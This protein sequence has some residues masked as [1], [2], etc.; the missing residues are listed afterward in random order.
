MEQEAALLQ[1]WSREREA[2]DELTRDMM[3]FAALRFG[4]RLEEAWKDFEMCDIPEPLDEH[5]N[6]RQIF[7]PYF[8]FHWDPFGPRSGKATQGYSGV[9][10]RAY[11]LESEDQLSDMER[12]FLEQAV[13][14]PV[15]F[16]EVLWNKPGERMDLR[17]I[18]MGGDVEVFER[19]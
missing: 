12:L 6:E 9:V 10:A 4:E 7:M 16:Y 17:D 13:T 1:L 2:C 19:S 14:R 5:E 18:L 8:L 3:K 15:S 11:E